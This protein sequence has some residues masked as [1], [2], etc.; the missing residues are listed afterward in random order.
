MKILVVDNYDSFTYNLV[1]Y[2]GQLGCSVEVYRNDE[3]RLSNIQEIAPDRI[4]I[5]PGPGVPKDAGIS[6]SLVKEFA[7][8]IPILGVCLGHQVI[9]EAFGGTV[10]EATELMHGK[11]SQI[12]HEQDS[13]LV[14]LPSPFEATRYHSLILSRQDL[15]EFLLVNAWTNR[16]VIMGVRHSEY[17]IFGVQFHPE[18]VMTPEGMKILE[19]FL[20]LL[21]STIKH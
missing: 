9:G 5:S 4:V 15:P 7:G 17:A 11:I 8:K 3:I 1:Q 14:G 10:V 20:G 16:D 19:N 12:Y 2:L 18:S 13:I 21:E 6:L